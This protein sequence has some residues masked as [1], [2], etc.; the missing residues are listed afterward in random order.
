MTPP[1]AHTFPASHI[2]QLVAL[3][4]RW[5]VTAEELL[6]GFG[7]NEAELAQPHARVSVETLC[8]LSERARALSGEPGIGFYLGMQKRL[9]MY[10]YLGFATQSAATLREGLELAVRFGPTVSTALS[11]QL[12]VEGAIASLEIEEH[13]ELGPTHDIGLFSL[14]V[15]MRQIGAL[16]LGRE[17]EQVTT[18]LPIEKP[19]YF[20]RFS[21]LLPDVRFERPKLCVHFP[22]AALDLPLVA[23]DRAALLLARE[24]CERQ[25]SELVFERQLPMRVRRLAFADSGP[26]NIDGVARALHMSVRTLKR[27]LAAEGETFSA[28]LERERHER[29][30]AMLRTPLTLDE[31]AQRLGYSSVPNF[32]RAF[33]RWRG[34]T[35]AQYRGVNSHRHRP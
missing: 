11:F 3:L 29:S 12:V 26:R 21:K 14:L 24:A 10:G 23:P 15:G 30:L 2:L 4:R 33:R 28:L 7:L 20:E 9:S 32:A 35:P 22:A 19:A 18:D 6:D 13:V 5:D 1:A 34:E 8:A 25:L 16:L 27:R 31:I 17:L